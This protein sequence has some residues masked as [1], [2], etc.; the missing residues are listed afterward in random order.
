ML[1]KSGNFATGGEFAVR[2]PNGAAGKA[3]SLAIE[4][5]EDSQGMYLL[6]VPP[7]LI[8]RPDLLLVPRKKD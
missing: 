6:G 1:K 2:V 7:Y 8:Q 5:C 4:D 3:W